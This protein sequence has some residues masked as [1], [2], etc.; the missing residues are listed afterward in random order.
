MDE[1]IEKTIPDS[2]T[3]LA[4]CTI[5]YRC[6]N[7]RIWLSADNCQV[8]TWTSQNLATRTANS[9]FWSWLTHPLLWR[10]KSKIPNLQ[11]YLLKKANS[12]KLG[13][14]NPC[15]IVFFW[16]CGWTSAGRGLMTWHS[17]NRG[18]F[19]YAMIPRC[20]P[21]S[22]LAFFVVRPQLSSS[23]PDFSKPSY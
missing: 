4:G 2:Y 17:W 1:S 23:N 11:I 3:W 21:S 9:D 22:R 5:Y 10:F 6:D 7:R 13:I 19:S 20:C 14:G 12:E 15:R 16:V 18:V 8:P